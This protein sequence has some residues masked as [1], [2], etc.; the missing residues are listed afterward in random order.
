MDELI[1]EAVAAG[2]GLSRGNEPAAVCPSDGAVEFFGQQVAAMLRE[3][4]EDMTVA[5]LRD[6]IDG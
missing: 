2:A 1:R 6:A 5:E 3:L 4:P